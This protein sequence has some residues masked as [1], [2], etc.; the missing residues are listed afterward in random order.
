MAEYRLFDPEN[1]PEWLDPEWWEHQPHCNHL[2]SPTGAHVAR[3]HAAAE[4][5]VKAAG[6]MP[7]LGY[8]VNQIAD[9]GAGDGALLELIGRRPHAWGY[10]IIR[11]DV[12]Y[13]REVRRVEVHFRNVRKALEDGGLS[14]GAPEYQNVI[15]V[16]T[17]VLEHM[18][19][20]HGLLKLLRA[21]P[22]VSHIVASSPWGETPD[23]H[24]WNHA[25]AWDPKGYMDMFMDAGW[26]PVGVM[27]KVEW[28]QLWR[29]APRDAGS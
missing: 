2:E 20:P 18:A 4:L 7:E 15:V 1:P 14:L 26:D 19:D 9:L 21:R 29:F 17:E 5:A 27:R 6:P 22:E 10:D 13:A 24:E 12:K 11:A 3:L 23:K 28:S 8:I 25:W 16:L